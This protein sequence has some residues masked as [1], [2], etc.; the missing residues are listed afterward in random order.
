MLG[1]ARVTCST[2]SRVLRFA[3]RRDRHRRAASAP[4]GSAPAKRSLMCTAALASGSGKAALALAGDGEHA[5]LQIDLERGRIDAR[6]KGIDLDGCG[7]PP[8]FRAGKP[9]RPK[10]RMVGDRSKACCISRCR[11]SISANMSRGNKDRYMAKPPN[12]VDGIAGAPALPDCH[13]WSASANFK[14]CVQAGGAAGHCRLDV[15]RSQTRC[16]EVVSA[17][18]WQRPAPPTPAVPRLRSSAR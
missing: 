2:P 13:S 15:A 7:V 8:T 6:R 9:L 14:G 16:E 4:G 12:Q 17:G 3:P 5:A 18:S 11:R 10:P 1:A